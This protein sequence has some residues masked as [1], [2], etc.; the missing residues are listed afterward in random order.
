MSLE[1]SDDEHVSVLLTTTFMAIT[2]AKGISELCVKDFER[3]MY[4]VAS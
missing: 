1:P 4:D 2:V 3:R